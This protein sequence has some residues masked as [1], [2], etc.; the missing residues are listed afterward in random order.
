[1]LNLNRLE[2][3]EPQPASPKGAVRRGEG[4]FTM[5]EIIMVVVILGILMS[6]LVGA[7]FGQGDKAKASLN[8]TQMTQLKAKIDLFR[9]EYNQ[10][11]P[12]LNSLVSCDQVTGPACAPS[13]AQKD[14]NDPWGTPFQYVLKNNGSR[15]ELRSLGADKS[16]G[17]ETVN[18]DISL[19]GP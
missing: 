1:M 16:P 8:K 13:L 15:Y 2:D 9:I 3:H 14:L 18:S 6:F 19:E 5:L 12:S 17:G 11:P 7:I 4:G 10:F